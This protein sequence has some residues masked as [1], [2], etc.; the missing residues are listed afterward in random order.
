MIS[1]HLMDQ[2][3]CNGLDLRV[4]TEFQI[5]FHVLLTSAACSAGLPPVLCI[6][7]GLAALRFDAVCIKH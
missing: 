1:A 4:T 2:F 7:A 5:V 3:F 6:C